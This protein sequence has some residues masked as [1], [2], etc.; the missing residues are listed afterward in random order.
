MEKIQ[1]RE[2][3]SIDNI[4]I[5]RSNEETLQ[6]NVNIITRHLKRINLKCNTEKTG[7][8]SLTHN[9][10]IEGQDIEQ[11]GMFKY[12]GGIINSKGKEDEINE[13]KL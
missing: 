13:R 2:L 1:I 6:E 5:F 11:V 12:L 10:K 9:I 3:Y 7:N 8:E 4:V